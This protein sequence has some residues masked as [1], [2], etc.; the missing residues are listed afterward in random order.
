[1]TKRVTAADNEHRS[2]QGA[3]PMPEE[4]DLGLEEGAK[5]RPFGGVHYS[6]SKLVVGAQLTPRW[7]GPC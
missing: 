5:A 7:R 6:V 4:G 2:K 3:L 1:V